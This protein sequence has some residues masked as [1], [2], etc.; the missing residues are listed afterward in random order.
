MKQDAILRAGVARVDITP[1]VGVEMVGFAARGPNTGQH[2]PLT[3]TALVLAAGRRRAAVVAC[4]LCFMGVEEADAI[5]ERVHRRCRVPAENVLICCS[6]TH[7][8]PA[9][10]SLGDSRADALPGPYHAD[11]ELKIAGAVEEAASNLAPVRAAVASGHC[12]ANINRR[13]RRPDGSIVLGRNPDGTVDREVGIVRLD[14]L[15]GT[16]LAVLV[17]WACHAVCLGSGWT[18]FSADFVGAMRGIVE[19]IVDA[20][21][22]FLQGACGN[23]NP[24][25]LAGTYDS[26]FRTG[27][28][29]AGEVLKLWAAAESE[30]AVGLDAADARL[31]YPAFRGISLEDARARLE[32][33]R[34]RLAGARKRGGRGPLL[35]WFQRNVDRDEAAVRYWTEGGESPAMT[36]VEGR[37]HALRF[38]P[39]ALAAA[40]GEVFCQIG[41]QARQRSPF[42]FTMFAG[43]TNADIMYI[44]TP[45]AYAEGGYEVEMAC[46]V[47]PASAGMLLDTT[48]DLL[49]RIW[50]DGSP[51]RKAAKAV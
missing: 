49:N 13:E 20:P 41:M 23:I 28:R 30:P 5:A 37:V 12:D 39:A 7:Y 22:L 9:M 2:D 6:H 42:P 24:P 27:A 4:D 16:P 43:Y 15:D 40:S 18:L 31:Q 14:A 45:E 21:V 50:T 10:R 47:D 17:N 36:P 33:S 29:L 51:S 26:A 11:L 19:P 38:G 34:S 25:R 8:G 46:K 44:P 35:H 1:P 48:R 32:R 3:A